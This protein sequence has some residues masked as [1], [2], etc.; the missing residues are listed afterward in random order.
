MAAA[1]GT[2]RK[3]VKKRTKAR[4]ATDKKTLSIFMPAPIDRDFA[5]YT[6]RPILRCNMRLIYDLWQPMIANIFPFIILKG[7]FHDTAQAA[8][9][10]IPGQNAD[11]HPL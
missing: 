6:R 10:T 11:S 5:P 9:H 7:D 8:S 2:R 3:K 4:L 1:G